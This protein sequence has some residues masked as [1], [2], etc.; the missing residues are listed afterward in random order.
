MN[1]KCA[2]QWQHDNKFQHLNEAFYNYIYICV[3]IPFHYFVLSLSI[4]GASSAVQLCFLLIF[5]PIPNPLHLLLAVLLT[6]CSPALLLLQSRLGPQWSHPLTASFVGWL[7]SSTFS[8][9]I[10][11]CP[12]RSHFGLLRQQLPHLKLYLYF[13]AVT[14]ENSANWPRNPYK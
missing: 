6:Q 1:S 5:L 9:S 2:F 8:S 14:N 4:T 13:E 3:Y 7:C 10:Q 12:N 11:L